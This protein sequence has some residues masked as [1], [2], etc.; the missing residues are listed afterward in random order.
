M[1]SDR[2]R[3]LASDEKFIQAYNAGVSY[4]DIAKRFRASTATIHRAV[5]C[6]GLECRTERKDEKAPTPEDAVASLEGLALSPTVFALAEPFRQRHEERRQAQTD[7][8]L[9]FKRWRLENR[10]PRG[11][12][13]QQG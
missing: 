4:K 1:F 8:A 10:R 12:K 6:A 9:Y 11:R 3:D 13:S 2:V 7:E 5:K